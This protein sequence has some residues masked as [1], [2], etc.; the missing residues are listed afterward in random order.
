MSNS[1]MT[2]HEVEPGWWYRWPRDGLDLVT[3]HPLGFVLL[4]VFVSVLDFMPQFVFTAAISIMIGAVVMSWARSADH[5]S[6]AHFW[7]ILRS[8]VLDAAHLARDVFIYVLIIGMIML[9]V[10]HFA[11]GMGYTAGLKTPAVDLIWVHIPAWIKQVFANAQADQLVSVS[12][13]FMFMLYIAMSMGNSGFGLLANQSLM[14]IFKNIEPAIVF[15][16]VG[17]LPDF[18][19]TLVHHL[20]FGWGVILS[21]VLVSV[22]NVILLIFGYLFAREAFDGQKKSV[23][24]EER[25]SVYGEGRERRLATVSSS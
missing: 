15:M 1:V 3:R 7:E 18:M 16:L 17:W 6:G 24:A 12:P 22:L 14:A 21:G 5:H 20:G 8:C 23:P 4:M 19:S 25:F 10:S 11:Q 13:W 9:V 2:P